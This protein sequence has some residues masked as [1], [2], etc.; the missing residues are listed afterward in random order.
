MRPPTSD[1]T[2]FPRKVVD[3]GR[4]WWRN[5]GPLGPW[6]FGSG[7]HGRFD[8][9]SPGG[10]LYLASSAECA[11]RERIGFDQVRAGFVTASEVADR[12]LSEVTLPTAV[13]A[14]HTT[15]AD[16]LRWG[17]V[18]LELAGTDDYTLTRAWA[19]AFAAAGFGGLWTLLRFS[20]PHGRGLVV[21]GDEG[22][23]SWPVPAT[24]TPLRE[25]V[26][27]TMGLRVV[28]PPH[29]SGLTVLA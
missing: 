21:F 13:D 23:R 22:P 16:G 5:H 4:R 27:T 7:P 10:T 25:F 8:L 17:V 19:G 24:S 6:F 11:T 28:D 26:E 29:S 20:G 15:S 3:A 2:G 14:A 1:L 12:Y 18:A 9:D